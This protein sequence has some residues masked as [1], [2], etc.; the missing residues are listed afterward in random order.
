MPGSVTES[1]YQCTHGLSDAV[2]SFEVSLTEV[3]IDA[4]TQLWNVQQAMWFC[5]KYH[6]KV[7]N[8]HHSLGT[9][10]CFLI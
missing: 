2:A 10:A 6:P 1:L 3:L 7:G 5:Q 8:R 9:W 4:R